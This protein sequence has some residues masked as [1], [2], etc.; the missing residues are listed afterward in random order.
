MTETNTW[1]TLFFFC[2]G[3][4]LIGMG[5]MRMRWEDKPALVS[6]AVLTMGVF[7]VALNGALLAHSLGLV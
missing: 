2:L 7:N 3:G 1:A 6:S 5:A 4:V